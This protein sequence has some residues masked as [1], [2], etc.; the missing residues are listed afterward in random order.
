MKEEAPEVKTRV[1][2]AGDA[3]TIAFILGEAFA[4]Y[5]PLYTK[6]AYAATTPKRDAILN[7]VAEGQ[8][9]VA[10]LDEK[11]VGA[12][13]AVPRGADLYIRSMAVLP[14]ARGNRIGERLLEEIEDFATRSGFERL[15]LST[16]PFLQCAIRL[17]E[18]FGFVRNGTDDLYGTPLVT[19]E[20]DL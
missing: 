16:T 3:E 19:M 8:T 10:L 1:A 13:S 17:Y 5:E 12:V 15:T 2:E 14:K 18:N 7:R 6:E 9:W 4:E 20:K 11:I